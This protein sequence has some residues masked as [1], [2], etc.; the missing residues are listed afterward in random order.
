MLAQKSTPKPRAF[1]KR[2]GFSLI[3]AM[4]LMSLMLI[5]ALS[6]ATFTSVEL[7]TTEQK[8]S[9][10]TARSNALLGLQIALGQLQ[11]E[12]GPDQRITASADIIGADREVR[13]WVGV[14]DTTITDPELDIPV[15][16]VSGDMQPDEWT[17]SWDRYGE[18]ISTNDA[19]LVGAN[20]VDLDIDENDNELPDDLVGAPK[21]DIERDGILVGKYAYAV[22]DE[23]L[24]ARVNLA[25]TQ[26][27]WSSAPQ[28]SEGRMNLST[29]NVNGF[30]S[31]SDFSSVD[32]DDADTIGR[33]ERSQI[34]SDLSLAVAGNLPDI[35]SSRK[36]Y[37]NLTTVSQGLQTNVVNGG[38]KKDLSLVF[39]M[40]DAN[41]RQSEFADDLTIPTATDVSFL[42]V[43]EYPDDG[44]LVRGPTWD[45]LRNYYR[46]YK[47][48]P[49]RTL[50]PTLRTQGMRPNR[51]EI[52]NKYNYIT[53]MP[54]D[55]NGDTRR[56]D[57][58]VNRL[59]QY[60]AVPFPVEM[61]ISPVIQRFMLLFTLTKD[62]SG[63]LNYVIKPMVILWNPYNVALEFDCIAVL[64]NKLDF[65]LNTEL[66][67]TDGDTDE[68]STY[69]FKPA[70]MSGGS[71]AN[72]VTTYM[73]MYI[74]DGDE[75]T[76]ND[77]TILE[78]GESKVFS[79]AG[80][81]PQKLKESSQNRFVPRINLVEGWNPFGGI[82]ADQFMRKRIS[83][84]A[85]A[86]GVMQDVEN[87]TWETIA[88]SDIENGVVQMTLGTLDSPNFALQMYHLTEGSDL[89]DA[90]DGL[91][92]S[93]IHDHLY[94]M[95][96]YVNVEG[97]TNV[98][99][100]FEEVP[101]TATTFPSSS[102]EIPLGLFDMYTRTVETA[103]RPTNLGAT[104]NIRGLLTNRKFA[105]QQIASG[106]EVFL[107]TRMSTPGSID[108]SDSNIPDGTNVYWGSSLDAS[109]GHTHTPFFDIPTTPPLSLGDL[110]HADI[111]PSYFTPSLAIGN[112]RA[113]PLIN[114][115]LKTDRSGVG[116]YTLSDVS[117]L[118]NEALFDNYFM[119]GIVPEV[120]YGALTYA[121]T[122]SVEEVIEDHFDNGSR[123]SLNQRIVTNI[124]IAGDDLKDELVINHRLADDAYL[125][126]AALLSVIGQFNVNSTSAEA[127]AV[128]LHS[129]RN[130]AIAR[131]NTDGSVTA[132]S[133]DPR[134]DN[135]VWSRLSI[136]LNMDSF[137]DSD[138]N[139]WKGW[140]NLTDDQINNLAEAIV[141]Q[142]K[143]R[144]PFKSYADFV[145]RKLIDEDDDIDN[146]GLQ[147]ALQA[148]IELADINA[149]V[150]SNAGSQ[151]EHERNYVA[152]D[153]AFDES[154]AGIPGF[155]MQGDL[156][157]PLAP[158]LSVRSDTFIIRSYGETVD[159][160]THEIKAKAWCEAV[161]QR[162]PEYI[163]STAPD[164]T[165]QEP[166]I[167]PELLSNENQNFG[168]RFKILSFRWL[169]SNDV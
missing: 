81:E 28:T 99:D 148:A 78:P 107:D 9:L 89:E 59:H 27:G 51:I 4:T 31:L 134:L 149:E 48:I 98:S 126:T 133:S 117:Y 169:Q 20:S 46:L 139:P 65:Q 138:A 97:I 141:Q 60:G 13:N 112:S 123:L 162:I 1:K 15:W 128:L 24:K 158:I 44:A 57:H 23:G 80:N 147:G 49:S 72:A 50:Q 122:R 161:V 85:D 111:S 132:L 18:S 119:S 121:E 86:D 125:K 76:I 110:R 39:E 8:E 43:E 163:E 160:Y 83:Q 120:N 3:I 2:R 146:L 159:P 118:A 155:L 96:P 143:L 5:L 106:D 7:S 109:T 92:D 19:I 69:Y 145:N 87:I 77:P 14:W 17:P 130:Q 151:P 103:A 22:S 37:H 61:Q 84:E 168:R 10:A 45:V 167:A 52:G 127:W 115:E 58:F 102:V 113:S 157:A 73:R 166:W 129:L 135:S 91:S 54:L 40:D 71:S 165:E 164:G 153:H 66:T 67:F 68:Q 142:V 79:I 21:V 47:E 33:I 116:R 29:V 36:H 152:P 156:L 25:P 124:D 16:L 137:S 64:F 38:L 94:N 136:P 42:Y 100:V 82:S 56:N 55:G 41:F 154:A 104:L 140:N 114:R 101:I 74:M 62:S 108:L 35:T 32:M 6:M 88:M 63:N 53:L 12:A 11:K 75:T 150:K 70:L 144:G 30:N 90:Y 95:Q 34:Y 105:N 131:V 93:S 26:S